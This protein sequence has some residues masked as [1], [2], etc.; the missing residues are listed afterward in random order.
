[1]TL[2]QATEKVQQLA[3][4]HG[5]KLQSKINFQ[6]GSGSIFL[7]DT[8]SPIQISNNTGDADCTIIISLEDFGK[9][10]NGQLNPMMAFMGGK[11]KVE[12][13]KSV[14]MKL[15]GLF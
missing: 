8:V 1:M 5:G 10:A 11:M 4:T 14:A 6:F 2:Q 9:L 7:D 12:G 13:D 3:A 15:S